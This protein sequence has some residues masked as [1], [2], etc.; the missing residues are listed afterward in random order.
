VKEHTYKYNF[1]KVALKSIL[2]WFGILCQIGLSIYQLF[3][4]GFNERS[5][6][7]LIFTN[8]IFSILNLPGF[9]LHLNHL[10]RTRNVQLILRYNTISYITKSSET[11]LNTFDISKIILHKG[12]TNSRLPWW[13]YSWF[14]LI[15]KEGKTIKVSYYLL[16]ISDLWFNTLSRRISSDNIEKEKSILPLIK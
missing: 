12:P 16:E 9:I 15:D 8:V 2:I 11:T 5:I 3:E 14:E 4:F 13:N 6:T 1:R 7:A 10:R